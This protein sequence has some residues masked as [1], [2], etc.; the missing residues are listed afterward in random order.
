M[1]CE[2]YCE[3]PCD[4]Y[5][6]IAKCAIAKLGHSENSVCK[7]DIRNTESRGSLGESLKRGGVMVA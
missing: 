7:G 3:S 6:R 1:F 4:A 2:N 5:G